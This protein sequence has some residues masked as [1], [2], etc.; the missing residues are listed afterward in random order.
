MKKV[1]TKE[2]ILENKG[3]YENH[4]VMALPCIENEK[5]Q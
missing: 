5:L 3:C 4:Q 2:Y 1:F